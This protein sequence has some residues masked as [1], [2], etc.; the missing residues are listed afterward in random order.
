[1]V[2]TKGEVLQNGFIAN[3]FGDVIQS[4]D[5]FVSQE[6]NLKIGVPEAIR[7]PDL[8]LRRVPLY[9]AELQGRRIVDP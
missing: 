8:H 7:T 4:D 1:M 6:L 3:L 2:D 9:P 5:Y